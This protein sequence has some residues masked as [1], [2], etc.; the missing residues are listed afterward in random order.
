[1][2]NIQRSRRPPPHCPYRQ[3]NGRYVKD[4]GR[5][6][7]SCFLQSYTFLMQYCCCFVDDRDRAWNT[8]LAV[9]HSQSLLDERVQNELNQVLAVHLQVSHRSSSV[10]L[11]AAAELAV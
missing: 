9:L 5:Q 11:H 3:V 8:L 1:M 6:Y 10:V 4:H 7:A 2:R